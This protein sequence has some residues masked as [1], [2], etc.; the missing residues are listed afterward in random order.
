[1]NKLQAIISPTIGIF[2]NIGPAHSENFINIRQ[3]VGEKLNLFTKVETL[4]YCPDYPEIQETIIKSEILNS[5]KD[6]AKIFC[7]LE[8]REKIKDTLAKIKEMDEGIS[9]VVSGVI[10]RVREI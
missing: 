2:T 9:I 8:N 4:I 1:M 7:V 6:G 5:I 10:D 3:K